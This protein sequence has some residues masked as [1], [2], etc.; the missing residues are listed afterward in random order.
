[1]TRALRMS[2]LESAYVVKTTV[3]IHMHRY[4]V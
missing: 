2:R 4:M 1:M 3:Y